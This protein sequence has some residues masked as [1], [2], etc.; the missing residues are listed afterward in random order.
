MP[1]TNLN[2]ENFDSSYD[3]EDIEEITERETF[4]EVELDAEHG[5]DSTE[6]KP[7]KDASVEAKIIGLTKQADAILAADIRPKEP[8]NDNNRTVE[9][10]PLRDQITRGRFGANADD[11]KSLLETLHRIRHLVDESE[12]DSLGLSVHAVG[13]VPTGDYDQQRSASGKP[14]YGSGQSLDR[15]S[16]TTETASGKTDRKH[17]GPVRKISKEKVSN[18]GFDVFRDDPFVFRTLGARHELDEIIAATGPNWPHLRRDS[19]TRSS[20]RSYETAPQEP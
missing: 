10:W 20:R 4:H 12:R 2:P 13:K 16:R 5:E 15:K 18:S 17:N 11:K 9:S 6:E 1:R 3:G 7:R 14:V 19:T 8:A